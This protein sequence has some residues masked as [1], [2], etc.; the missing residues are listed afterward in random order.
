MFANY[1]TLK[2]ISTHFT[3]KMCQITRIVQKK[4]FFKEPIVG[5]SKFLCLLISICSQLSDYI[6]KFAIFGHLTCNF[7]VLWPKMALFLQN[8]QNIKFKKSKLSVGRTD[9]ILLNPIF[10]WHVHFLSRRTLG[11]APSSAAPC[12]L[13]A[14]CFRLVKTSDVFCNFY[15]TLQKVIQPGAHWRTPSPW[16]RLA[17]TPGGHWG[18]PPRS[19]GPLLKILLSK[20]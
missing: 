3:N 9:R 16:P 1:V 7:C 17:I 4:R 20:N 11:L 15:Y 5:F 8:F 2:L 10:V 18:P 6:K 13:G 19:P 14:L 12:S